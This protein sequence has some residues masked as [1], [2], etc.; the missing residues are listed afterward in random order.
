MLS[1]TYKPLMLSVIMLNAVMLNVAAPKPNVKFFGG[2][3]I[4]VLSSSNVVDL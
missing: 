4:Q 3:P 2:S 1:V